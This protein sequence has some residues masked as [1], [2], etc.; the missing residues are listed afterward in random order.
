MSRPEED[1]TALSYYTSPGPMTILSG[2]W[3]EVPKDA[4]A[5]A[6]LVADLGIYD[7]F[8]KAFY[9]EDL[10]E[11]RKAEIS[12]RPAEAMVKRLKEL[13]TDIFAERSPAERLV[14]RCRN[15]A[16]LAV[17]LCRAKGIPARA[18]C[19]FASYFCSSYEDHWIL[20]YWDN[21]LWHRTDPQLDSVW[22]A[23]KKLTTRKL[24]KNQ[25]LT[26]AEAWIMWRSDKAVDPDDFGLSFADL[27]GPWFMAGNL[28]R[29]VTSLAKLELLPWDVWGAMPKP[30][31]DIKDLLFFDH[32]AELALDPDKHFSE[33]FHLCSSN[34]GDPKIQFPTAVFN[35][36]TEQVDH[37]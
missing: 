18:R 37:L 13:K 3:T 34:G 22:L 25:F 1:D 17:A 12:L 4:E 8:A 21:G 33:I 26:A 6:G 32:L 24:E 23:R 7:V 15:Y 28:I 35:V 5:I 16:V 36:L 29:D 10:T 31:E 9:D 14:C 20:E 30:N 11:S 2:S 27:K 19:G